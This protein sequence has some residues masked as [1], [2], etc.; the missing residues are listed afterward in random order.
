M[1]VFG[2]FTSVSCIVLEQMLFIDMVITIVISDASVLH[3]CF[4]W[5]LLC[6]DTNSEIFSFNKCVWNSVLSLSSAVEIK[7]VVSF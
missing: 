5:C 3:I 4:G 6:W 7:T 1:R 2:S